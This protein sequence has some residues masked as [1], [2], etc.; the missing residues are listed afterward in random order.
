MTQSSALR[1]NKNSDYLKIDDSIN[2]R[3]N[4]TTRFNVHSIYSK[5]W[6]QDLFL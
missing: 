1:K 3:N 5:I 2:N 4:K 6:L